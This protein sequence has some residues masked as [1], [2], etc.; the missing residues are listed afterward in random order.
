MSELNLENEN[1][2]VEWNGVGTCF[3]RDRRV[4]QRAF[5]DK[6]CGPLD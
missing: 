1:D 4:A 3:Y 2:L 6:I 5:E